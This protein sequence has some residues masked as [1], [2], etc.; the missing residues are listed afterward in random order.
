MTTGRAHRIYLRREFEAALQKQ[1][2]KLGVKI[3]D[4]IKTKIDSSDLESIR[5][6]LKELIERTKHLELAIVNLSQLLQAKSVDSVYTQGVKP[7]Q[8]SAQK[9]KIKNE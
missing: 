9:V 6:E 7:S 5:T 4:L 2:E 3:D 1:A 8:K